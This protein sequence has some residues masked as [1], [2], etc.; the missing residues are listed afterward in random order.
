[1]NSADIL[2]VSQQSSTMAQQLSQTTTVSNIVYITNGRVT[3][4]M[5]KEVSESK[6]KDQRELMFS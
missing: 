5:K 1:M 2:K 3:I 6:G 4:T